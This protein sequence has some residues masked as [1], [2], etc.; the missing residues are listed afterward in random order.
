MPLPIEPPLP[1]TALRLGYAGVAPFVGGAALIW[2][3]NAEAHE[4]A[5]L[6]L[7]AYAALVISFLGGIHWGL[8]MARGVPRAPL[9]IWGVTPVLLA[10][11]ALV[12]PPR[13]GLAIDG[14]L[15]VAGYLVD[16]KVYPAQG[17]GRWLT[18]RFR[19]AAIGAL[20]CFL[21]AAGA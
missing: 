11:V 17:I 13:S 20:A 4:Y 7:A 12:M 16:R 21:G 9:F 2:I 5:A 10:W 18:L 14:V 3:V 15:L 8:A 1:D 6:A 19:L